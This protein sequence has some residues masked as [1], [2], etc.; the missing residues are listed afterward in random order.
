[1]LLEHRDHVERRILHD[2]RRARLVAPVAPDRVL[3]L[4]FRELNRAAQPR[5]R[6]RERVLVLRRAARPNSRRRSPRS[7]CCCGRE[8]GRAARASGSGG[9]DSPPTAACRL[10]IP[11]DLRAEE[12]AQEEDQ[13]GAHDDGRGASAPDDVI[14][15]KAHAVRTSI[16]GFN[17]DNAITPATAVTAAE[18]GDQ[19]NICIAI[20]APWA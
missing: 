8:S 4:L 5:E 3:E 7:A 2:D 6:R 15:V 10:L 19:T 17:N 20:S 16:S 14:R 12:R 11:H 1:M 18:S 9:A 13:H